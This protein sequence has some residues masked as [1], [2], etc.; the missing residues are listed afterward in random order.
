MC[1]DSSHTGISIRSDNATAIACLN[2]GGSTKFGLNS[3]VEE[4]FDWA[5]ARGITLSAQFLEGLDNV[6]ADRESRVK[7]V[8]TEWMLKPRIFKRIYDFFFI[9]HM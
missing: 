7:N 3:I 8:D 4:I 1:K 2:R 5:L 9:T 6:E